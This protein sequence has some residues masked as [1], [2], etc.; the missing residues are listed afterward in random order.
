M[1]TEV[2]I[3]VNLNDFYDVARNDIASLIGG[4]AVK[5]AAIFNA[6]GRDVSFSVYNYADTVNW[7]PAQKT[8]IADAHRG[9]V[10]ASGVLFKI[11]PNS[12][13]DAEFLV[14]P[15]KAYI[16]HGQGKVEEVTN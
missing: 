11:H 1:D 15:G 16:F 7:V 12:N 2:E 6:S 4:A 8:L 10:A 14:A 13:K 5:A 9:S 3:S